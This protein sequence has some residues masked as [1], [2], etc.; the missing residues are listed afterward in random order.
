MA[1]PTIVDDITE[2]LAYRIAAG[3]YR[4]GDLLPSVRQLATEFAAS[5]P[6]ANNALGRLAALGFAEPRRGLGYLVRDIQLY[7]GIDMWRIVFRFAHRVPERAAA[8]FAD[9]IDIDHQLVMQA[10]RLFA[11]DPG[12]YDLTPALHALNQLELLVADDK[13]DLTDIMAAELHALRCAFAIL[14]KPGSL[15]LFNTVGE[16]LLSV[17]EAGPAFYGPL[18]PAGHVLVVRTLLELR[19]PDATDGEPLDLDLVD[20]LMRAYHDQV[21]ETFRELITKSAAAEDERSTTSA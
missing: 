10:V 18:E 1:K 16:M 19:L 20:S 13:A 3:I 21:V 14:G 15:A 9:I 17:P 8:C 4:P 11:D 12:R 5:T 7:G 2:Q 6:T